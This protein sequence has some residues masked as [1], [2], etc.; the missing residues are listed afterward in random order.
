MNSKDYTILEL[1]D[2]EELQEAAR[3]VNQAMIDSVPPPSK[4]KH[5][6]SP[7]FQS[8]MAHLIA[9]SKFMD[10]VQQLGKQVATALLILVVG[11]TSWLIVD[12]KAR[13][14]LFDWVRD[15]Y[16]NSIV[17]RFFVGD[18]R[19]FQKMPSYRPSW[20]PDGYSQIYVSDDNNSQTVIY[21]KDQ[22]IAE[23][24]ILDYRPYS[25]DMQIE[26][27]WEETEYE[28]LQVQVNKYPAYF[29]RSLDGSQAN[30]LV[31]VDEAADL[32]FSLNGY[33]EKDVML[34]IADSIKLV[35]MHEK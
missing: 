5:T 4:C 8:K 17:Y 23:T 28:Y 30:D 20:L 3:L 10:T 14:E 32:M 1:F 15:V 2:E 9:R 22:N 11:V 7:A 24:I 21:Q 25:N 26:L 31:W 33:L 34:N 35:D 27:M 6:F 13:V 19:V 18:A 29:Y 12:A 16:E